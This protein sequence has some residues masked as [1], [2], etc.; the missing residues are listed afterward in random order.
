MDV[1][2]TEI[3]QLK[4]LENQKI[5]STD[6]KIDRHTRCEHGKRK[7]CCK[8]CKAAEFCQVNGLKS[9]NVV[10]INRKIDRHT[11]CE[12]GKRK[13]FCKQCQGGGICQHFNR[14]STCR[15]CKEN[16]LFNI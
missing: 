16:A 2:S 8:Q 9:I 3:C 4:G 14:K 11:K 10:S 5:V 1:N 13:Y 15:A 12:H 7:H 6:R